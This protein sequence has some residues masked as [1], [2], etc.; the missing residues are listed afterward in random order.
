MSYEINSELKWNGKIAM[1][2]FDKANLRA[3]TES[4]IL[5]E[6]KAV[7]KVH[8]KTGA[9]KQSITRVVEALRAVVGT[10]IE[11]APYEEFGTRFRD[12]HPFLRPSFLTSIKAIKNIFKKYNKAV[13]FVK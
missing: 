8:V 6:G 12:A 3:L 2:D 5:V 9:L 7:E 10:P 1:A 13:K 11:Y 4:A